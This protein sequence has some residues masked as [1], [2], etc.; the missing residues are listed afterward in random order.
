[1][2]GVYKITSPSGKIYVGQSID[3]DR[4]FY[5]YKLKRCK[6]QLKLYNSFLKYGIE[7]HSF[8]VIEECDLNILTEK[9]GYWQD[10]F[11]CIN[12]GLNCRKVST[13]D[14]TGYLSESTKEKMSI[15]AKKRKIPINTIKKAQEAN[16]KK[17]VN[18][19]T[20]EIYESCKE[21]AL[22][23]N[24]K[25]KVLSKRLCGLRKNNTNLIYLEDYAGTYDKLFDNAKAEIAIQREDKR[26]E[27]K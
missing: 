16:M 11:D 13:I 26:M 6:Y 5:Q 22:K 10:Y 19:I 4:R 12:N 9:E 23:N 15:A 8:E 1:M 18:L 14:K 3:I 21:A 2:I 7:N 20:N 25:H 17:V 27:N 24:T